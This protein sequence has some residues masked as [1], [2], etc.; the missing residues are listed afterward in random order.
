MSEEIGEEK[1]LLISDDSVIPEEDYVN[2]KLKEKNNAFAKLENDPRIIKIGRIIC[3]YS[4]DELPQF[5]NILKGDISIVSNHLLPFYEAEL[6]ISNEHI[7]RL[8]GLAGLIG[9][10]QVER[11]GEIDELPAG[12]HKQLG[13]TYAKAFS[14]RLDIKTILKA[15]ATFIQKENV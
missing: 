15:V 4:I 12:E 8:M 9:L 10:R 5:I 3:K 6:L 11:R 13:I 2:K 14:L 7:D 1:I